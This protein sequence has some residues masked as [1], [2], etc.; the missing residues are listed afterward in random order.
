VVGGEMVVVVGHRANSTRIRY[1]YKRSGVR[2]VEVDV[3]VSPDGRIIV[4]HGPPQTRRATPVGRL[5]AWLD[6]KLFYRDPLIGT[7]S[8]GEWIAKIAEDLGIEGVMLDL[9][10]RVDPEGL[11]REVEASGFRGE[12]LVSANDHRLL[13]PVREALARAGYNA[14]AIASFNVRPV[15]LVECARDSGADVVGVRHDFLDEE[16][17]ETIKRAGY[18]VS[19]WTVNRPEEAVRL[20]RAGVDYIVTDRPDLVIRRLRMEGVPVYGQPPEGPH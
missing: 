17:V 3:N 19:T 16:L 14:R 18:G 7:H 11:A 10:A 6:Y 4:R 9:K 13:K 1:W 5:W 20:A 2:Y 12:V 8:L 15:R